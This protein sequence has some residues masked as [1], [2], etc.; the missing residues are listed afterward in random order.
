M[1]TK[2]SPTV[3]A[4]RLA[5]PADVRLRDG[6]RYGLLVFVAL[7]IGLSLVALVATA[8]LPHAASLTPGANPVIPSPVGVPW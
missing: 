4:T 7:R 3:T 6:L 2:T 1:R 8:L 5:R